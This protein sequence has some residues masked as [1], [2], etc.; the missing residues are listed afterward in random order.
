MRDLKKSLFLLAFA[1]LFS[2][3]IIA[4]ENETAK[5]LQSYYVFDYMK[6]KPEMRKD[7]LALEK[8]WKKIH[9]KNINAGKYESWNLVRVASPSGVSSEYNFITR[10]RF[11]GEKAIAEHIENSSMPENWESLLTAEE[12][13][14]VKRGNEIRTWV[15]SETWTLG[16]II[17]PEGTKANVSVFNYFDYPEGSGRSDHFKVEKEIWKPVHQARINDGKLKGWVLTRMVMP[18]GTSMPYHDATVDLYDNIE[19]M[20]MDNPMP[21]FEKV[22][23]GKN[24]DKLLEETGAVSDLVRREVRINL[25]SAT[26]EKIAKVE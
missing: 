4:Q 25:D 21:Y 11:K 3:N 10:T 14:L 2:I 17:Y 8:A 9:L 19:Q 7:Y 26:K 1:C 15:K 23:P 18:V 16:D 20:M 6:V 13:A 5:K 12:I 24:V 22:H